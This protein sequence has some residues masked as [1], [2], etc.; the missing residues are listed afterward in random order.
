MTLVE[1]V[2]ALMI[3]GV[4]A[5]GVVSGL[6]FSRK[7]AENNLAQSYAQI[8]AQSIIEQIVRVPTSIL[9]DAAQ[10]GVRILIPFVTDDNTVTMQ[11]IQIPWTTSDLFTDV[12]PEDDPSRGVLV[13]VAY[14]AEGNTIRP[15]RYMKLRVNLQRFVDT[16]DSRTTIRLR[17]EYEIP[18]RKGPDGEPLFQSGELRTVRSRAESF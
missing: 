14:I 13:D 8:T 10:S 17:Y 2:I 7:H 3:F 4:M 5:G 9:E 11:D 15:M 18:D 12:G 16:A 1:A 6:I